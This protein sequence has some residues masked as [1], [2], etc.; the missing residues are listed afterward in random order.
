ML[1]IQDAQITLIASIMVPVTIFMAQSMRHTLYSYSMAVRKA[2]SNS[3]SG[4]QRYLEGVSVLRL[5]G[6]EESEAE[7]IK[8]AFTEQADNR[9]KE[10][11]LQQVMLPVYSLIAGLGIVVVIALGGQKVISGAWSVGTYNAFLVMFVALSTR[12]RVAAR[13]FNRWHGAR[14]AWSRVKEKMQIQSQLGSADIK[15]KQRVNQL[16]V[17]GLGFSYNGHKVLDDISFEAKKGQVIGITGSVGSGKTALAQALTGLYPYSGSILV[18]GEELSTIPAERRRSLIGYA[19]HEQFLFSMSIRENITMSSNQLDEA[20]LEEALEAAA[21][22]EDLKLFKDDLD[23]KVGERG[24]RV[25]G[26]QRQRI[27]LARA[28]YSDASILVLD[29]PFSAVDI[30]TEKRIVDQLK[31]AYSD[32]IVLLFTHRVTSFINADYIIVLHG[33]VLEERGTHREL[34]DHNGIY[35]EIFSAQKFMEESN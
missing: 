12:T 5:F 13:V 10:I 25:S 3:N 14:A 30:A 33:G 35:S 26:G 9:V 32:K 1:M 22:T 23:S 24:V 28:I 18:D 17:N 11:L 31:T 15:T 16:T 6:R 29:E 34:M 19:G 20:R 4:L 21:L 2:A 8:I 27:A 7:S